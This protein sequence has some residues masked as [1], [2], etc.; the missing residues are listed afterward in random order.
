MVY[1][2][3]IVKNKMKRI[4]TVVWLLIICIGTSRGVDLE[5]SQ[6]IDRLLSLSSPGS[7]IIYEDAV[8]FT[9]SSFE[10]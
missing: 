1:L 8:I 9:A 6:F 10:E 7:P 5:S 2:P 4:I 3:I